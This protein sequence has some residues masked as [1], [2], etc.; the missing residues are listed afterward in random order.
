[1]SITKEMKTIITFDRE[2]QLLGGFMDN[3]I[4]QNLGPTLKDECLAS[5]NT[6]E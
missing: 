4:H 5:E 3:G 6:R 1:M 2:K